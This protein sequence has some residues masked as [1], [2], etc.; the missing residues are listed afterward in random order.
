MAHLVRKINLLRCCSFSSLFLF[1][2][3]HLCYFLCVDVLPFSALC[4]SL[5]LHTLKL[6]H[7]YLNHILRFSNEAL[8]YLTM[9]YFTKVESQKGSKI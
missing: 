8:N 6:Q 3:F 1:T 5:P 2:Y 4:L 9:L 7:R